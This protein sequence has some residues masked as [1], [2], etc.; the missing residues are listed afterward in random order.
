MASEQ[1]FPAL[2]RRDVLAAANLRWLA[3]M[4][5]RAMWQL[6]KARLRF[7][8]LSMPKV[9]ARNEQIARSARGAAEAR[10]E[11]L[12]LVSRVAFL[13]PRIAK[14]M[15]FRT[16]CLVQALA[17]QEWL[18]AE[19]VASRV[20]IGVGT[21]KEEPFGAHAWLLFGEDVVTGGNVHKF[22]PL[23]GLQAGS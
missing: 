16:D 10:S 4:C 12:R 2:S 15:P 23:A 19:G 6:A 1:N 20:V 11:D 18:E 14:R 5:L 17:A 9:L 13:I 22:A 3:R 21:E 8:L 7:A